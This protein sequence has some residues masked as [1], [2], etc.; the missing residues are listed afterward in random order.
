V[1]AAAGEPVHNPKTQR[2][3]SHSSCG[4]RGER[5]AF[6]Q[7][8]DIGR[9]NAIGVFVGLGADPPNRTKLISIKSRAAGLWL[10]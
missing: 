4:R 10:F 3:K 9:K 1:P 6:R 5:L 2:L 7:I 8:I